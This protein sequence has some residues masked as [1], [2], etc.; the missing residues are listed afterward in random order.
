MLRDFLD[1][2]DSLEGY[3]RELGVRVTLAAM[4]ESDVAR[5]SQVTLRT[6]QFNLTAE[7]LQPAQVRSL[8]DDPAARV[9]TIRSADRFGDNGLRLFGLQLGAPVSLQIW[10]VADN[11]YA[12]NAPLQ[13]NMTDAGKYIYPSFETDLA[14]WEVLDAIKP[15]KM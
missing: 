14:V 15:L 5:V 12:F 7:R 10:D 6:N 4:T 2:F 1:T 9:L 3:L 13:W 11:G 8:L